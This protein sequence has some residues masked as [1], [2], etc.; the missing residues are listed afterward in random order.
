MNQTMHPPAGNHSTAFCLHRNFAVL[1]AVLT[2]IV[3]AGCNTGLQFNPLPAGEYYTL[4][5]S[6]SLTD[7]VE[8]DLVTA[9][10]TVRP[11]LMTMSD[12]TKFQL[13]SGDRTSWAARDGTFTLTKVPFSAETVLEARAGKI[14][15]RRRLFPRDLRETDVSKLR[16]TV[17]STAIALIWERAHQ[18]G[19]ELTEWDIAAREYQPAIASVT[20]AIRFALQMAPANVPGTILGLE[21]VKTPVLDAASLIEP[22]ESTLREALRV[23][24]NAVLRENHDLIANYVST[25]FGNDWDSSASWR[26]LLER[27]GTYFDGYDIPVASWTM[28]DMELL[29]GSKARIRLAMEARWSHF[30]SGTDGT[31][32]VFVSDIL[33]QKEGTFWKIIR[34]FPYKPTDPR[35]VG[36]DARWGQIAAAH[37]ELQAAL[38]NENMTVLESLVSPNFGNDWDLNSTWTDLMETAKARFDAC[39]VKI[40]T[41]SIGT[42]EFN[43]PDLARVHCSAQVRVIRLLPGIDVDSG[44][45]N[46]IVEW[47]RESGVW[48]LARNLPYRFSHPTNIR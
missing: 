43:G 13:V 22:R 29:P 14:A 42:I 40:A 45:I 28:L 46:A 24:E 4:A 3:S 10:P 27:T 30:F 16:I 1:I 44:P 6:I 21:M 26:D 34:N 35:Q 39:D 38:G 18:M 33:W 41:Y 23:L 12:Y 11:S 19:K 48:K 15:L 2:M 5:G 36:A 47:R 8:G 25:S 9:S 20:R 7:P 17:E 32:G 31:T 37:A